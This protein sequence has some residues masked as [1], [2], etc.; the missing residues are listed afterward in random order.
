MVETHARHGGVEDLLHVVRASH[1]ELQR[2][3]L[4]DQVGRML[5]GDRKVV[6]RVLGEVIALQASHKE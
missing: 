2:Y 4:D 3:G 5:R 6:V 1:L